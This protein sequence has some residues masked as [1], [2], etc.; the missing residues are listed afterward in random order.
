MKIILDG[1]KIK[2]WRED[3]AWSQEHL[4]DVA[5]IGLRTVQR[6]ENGEKA[7]RETVMALA[8]SFNV[9]AL[10]LSKNAEV[11]AAEMVENDL[12]KASEALRLSFLIHFASYILGMAVF[13]AISLSDG[14]GGYSMRIPALW[15][16]VGLIGHAMPLIIIELILRYKRRLNGAR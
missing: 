3:R 15:W 11:E 10:A 9:D 2:R 1:A 7:S 14:A 8:S 4:A 5:G 16:S 12:F 13:A 6:I